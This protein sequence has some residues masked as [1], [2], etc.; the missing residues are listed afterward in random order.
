MNI[1]GRGET[2]EALERAG[3]G[4]VVM[5]GRVRAGRTGDVNDVGVRG[6]GG[7]R[8]VSGVVGDVSGADGGREQDPCWRSPTLDMDL[9]T[10]TFFIVRYYIY[11]YIYIYIY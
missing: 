6:R 1:W 8:E 11:I 7:G 2:A 9:F 10:D 5:G 4:D 3:A